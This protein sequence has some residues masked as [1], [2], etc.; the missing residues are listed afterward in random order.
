MLSESAQCRSS[1]T[2]TTRS[3]SIRSSSSDWASPSR[4]ARGWRSSASARR[5]TTRS[6]S[7]GTRLATM[8]ST[9]LNGWLSPAGVGLAGEDPHL[10]RQAVEQLAHQTGLADAGLAPDER[11]AGRLGRQEGG[12]AVEGSGAAHHHRAEARSPCEHPAT[13]PTPRDSEA[14]VPA[15]RHAGPHAR[16]RALPTL[17]AWPSRNGG[18]AGCAAPRPCAAWWPRPVSASTTWSPR[19]SCARASTSPSRSRRCPASSSTP[20]TAS[21]RR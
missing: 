21:A 6:S 11:D 15:R 2:M 17:L 4:S 13:V 8:S 7:A 14:R 10:G 12:Q 20:V 5:A 19:S 9:T 1:N 18:C 3:P 16:R